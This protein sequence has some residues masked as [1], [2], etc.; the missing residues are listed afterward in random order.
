MSDAHGVLFVIGRGHDAVLTGLRER[1]FLDRDD[2]G[3]GVLFEHFDHARNGFGLGVE[4][5]NRIAEGDD[6]G[7]IS[8]EMLAGEDGV[9]QASGRALAGIEKLC[10]RGRLVN[11]EVEVVFNR[12]FITAGDEQNLLD[13][14]GSE[15]IDDVFDNRLAGDGQHFLGLRTGRGQQSGAEAGYGNNSAS[16]HFPFTI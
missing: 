8:G 5:E 16:N 13:S 14:I 3:G 2:A 10:G 11:A 4:A 7:L 15:L 1:N 12:R 9:T 6:E